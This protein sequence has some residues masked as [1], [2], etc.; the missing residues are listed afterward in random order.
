M[1]SQI[2]RLDEDAVR[3]DIRFRCICSYSKCKSVQDAFKG[4]THAY[5]RALMRFTI[6]KDTKLWNDFFDSLMR[7]LQ[8][9]KETEVN[10]R[11]QRPGYIFCVAAHHF[12]EQVVETYWND[13][14]NDYTKKWALRFSKEEAE[15]LLHPPLDENDTD[16]DGKY[17]INANY[18]ITEAARMAVA[19]KSRVSQTDLAA[20]HEETI[21][22]EKEVAVYRHMK[23]QREKRKAD[24]EIGNAASELLVK[25]HKCNNDDKKVIVISGVTSGLGRGLL[26]YYYLQG[27]IVCGCARTNEDVKSLQKLFPEAK[28]SVVNVASDISVASWADHLCDTLGVD[29]ANNNQR[30]KIDLVIANAGVSPETALENHAAWE[31]PRM[32]FDATIDINIKG[33][34]NMIRHFIPRMICDAKNRQS[35][36]SKCFVAISSGLGR[37]PNPY[38]AA[39]CASKFAIEG[40]M[41]SLAMSIPDPLSAVPLA[42]GI[43]ETGM[44]PGDGG[45]N[46]V[47]NWVQVAGPMILGLDRKDNGKSLSVDGFYS[48][49]YKD[50]WIIKDRVGIPEELGHDFTS[51]DKS[52]NAAGIDNS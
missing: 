39:Y 12:S 29:H 6:A 38:H 10:L 46:T 49:K 34:A 3:G 37:S 20:S 35:T 25:R 45:E 8:V 28:L 17:F 5:N 48:Q 21:R 33:V 26:E 23:H 43:V 4:T 22:T 32:D 40:M 44:M 31:V 9:N 15:K 24:V 52:E 47:S 11:L 2:E 36:N 1:S 51:T 16:A 19:I 41:K 30:L 7:N 14:A 13:H 50:T 18:P 42:P 27:H